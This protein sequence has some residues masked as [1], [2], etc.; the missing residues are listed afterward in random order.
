MSASPATCIYIYRVSPLNPSDNLTKLSPF[1][2]NKTMKG[3]VGTGLD[4]KR[5]Q[6]N[7]YL[8]QTKTTKYPNRLMALKY[9]MHIPI[10]L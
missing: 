7:G 9:I 6:G 5:I 8:I 10:F 2:I 3:M 4:I 1:A